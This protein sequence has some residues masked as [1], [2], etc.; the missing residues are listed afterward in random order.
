MPGE[1]FQE[2]MGTL[3]PASSA[4]DEKIVPPLLCVPKKQLIDA[5]A[6]GRL[7]G[8]AKLFVEEQQSAVVIDNL[9]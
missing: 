4:C 1:V 5:L 2:V 6:E 8:Q 7:S 3:A 9:N